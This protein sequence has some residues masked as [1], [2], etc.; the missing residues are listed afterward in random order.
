MGGILSFDSF[1]AEVRAHLCVLEIEPAFKI[2]AEIARFM[3]PPYT[4]ELQLLDHSH[5]MVAFSAHGQLV[6]TVEYV[7]DTASA[8]LVADGIIAVFEPDET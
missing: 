3:W 7:M 4:A 1:A 2:D 8:K 6:R 5:V